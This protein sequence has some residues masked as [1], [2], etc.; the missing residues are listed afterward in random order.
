MNITKRA[1]EER[2]HMDM[3]W[4]YT[5]HTFVFANYYDPRH[6]SW[7]PLRVINEDRVKASTGFGT[8]YIP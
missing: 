8:F 5:Y 2:G 7:G 4:L 3:G 1:W 6:M